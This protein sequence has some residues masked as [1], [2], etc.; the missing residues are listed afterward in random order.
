MKGNPEKRKTYKNC[1]NFIRRHEICRVWDVSL[2]HYPSQRLRVFCHLMRLYFAK[3]ATTMSP[4]SLIE[5]ICSLT[6]CQESSRIPQTFLILR[7][8]THTKC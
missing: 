1:I 7:I 5:L 6:C 2:S 8:A 3:R 4:Q